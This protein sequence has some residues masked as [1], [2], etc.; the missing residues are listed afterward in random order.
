MSATS[1]TQASR[2]AR[3]RAHP[4]LLVVGGVVLVGVVAFV[5]WWFQPQ[6]LL[7]DRVVDEEFPAV[8]AVPEPEPAPAETTTDDT[9][10]PE[11]A[12]DPPPS[13]DDLGAPE[14]VDAHGDE[15]T[16]QEAAAAEEPTGP[17]MLSSGGFESRNR[18]TVTGEATVYELEDGSRT[19]RLEPF[20]STNGPDLYVYLTTAD[21]ADDDDALAADA[22]DLGDLRGNIGSQNYPIPDDVDLDAYDTVVIWCERFTVA[23]GA[24]DLAPTAG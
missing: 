4:R 24:A 23:F 15:G 16:A 6:A 3:L 1:Q 12:D 18:Y 14:A 20:E 9:P 8:A 17:R 21:H 11:G 22:V 10:D 19:L 5:L 13:R 7:F 2:W